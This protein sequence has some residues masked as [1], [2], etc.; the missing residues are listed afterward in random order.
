[1]HG[2][3]G[4]GSGTKEEATAN[5]SSLNKSPASSI[6]KHL[7][8]TSEFGRIF[9][10]Q[11]MLTNLV[12]FWSSD[13]GKKRS[14]IGTKNHGKNRVPYY[15]GTRS[16]ARVRANEEAKGNKVDMLGTWL[17]THEP[18]KVSKPDDV[19]AMRKWE[20]TKMDMHKSLV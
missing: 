16:H 10:V 13:L 20:K 14:E 9:R 8:Y 5:S 3:R 7:T 11:D 15:S 6:A 19:S 12:E 2:F 17:L 4:R 1:M 18:K